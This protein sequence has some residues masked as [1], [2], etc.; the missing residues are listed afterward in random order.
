MLI[1]VENTGYKCRI[2]QE[3]MAEMEKKANGKTDGKMIKDR[4]IIVR[5]PVFNW[6]HSPLAVKLQTVFNRPSVLSRLQILYYIQKSGFNMAYL[7]FF[8]AHISCVKIHKLLLQRF[9]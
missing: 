8:H 5:V 3:R 4:S 2:K 6:I 9:V 1:T 7:D